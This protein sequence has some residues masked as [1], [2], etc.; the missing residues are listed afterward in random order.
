MK[1]VFMGTPEFA[2]VS[3]KR[4]YEDGHDICAVFTQPDKQQN[5]GLK[6]GL[7]PV[8]AL[9]LQHQTP[10]FQPSTLKGGIAASQLRQLNPELIAVV[11]YGKILPPDVLSLPQKG[12]INIH[13]SILPKYRGSAPVQWAVL[14]GEK[15][16]GVT[17]MYMA[18]EMDTGD[19]IMTKTTEIGEDDTAGTLFSRLSILGAVLLSE[20]ITAISSG[21]ASRIMQNDADATYAP[22]LTKEMSPID[23][24]KNAHE[25]L[26]QIRG[27]NPWPAATTVIDGMLYK[28][29]KAV[30]TDRQSGLIP[31][32]IVKAAAPD[33]MEIS[34]TDGTVIIKEL[35]APGGKRMTAADYLRGHPICR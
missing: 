16:T 21:T 17:S 28:I 27:L 9:A 8:K 24:T 7:G 3:L 32:S 33:V 30:G 10:V 23:W 12:C 26:C 35:Q 29:F 4:L 19:I 20:T 31:G 14:N 34:C 22:P 11:A 6:L 25:I 1:I 2:A 13:G 15:T 5:R 18:P